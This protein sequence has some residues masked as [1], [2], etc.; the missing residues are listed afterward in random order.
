VLPELERYY[1]A[2]PRSAARVEEVGPFTVFVGTGEWS[3]Y[4][5]PRLGLE[6]QFSVAD[7]EAAAARKREL[8]QPE[9]FE[10]VHETTPSLLPAAR[11]AALEV[12]EAPLMVLDRAAWRPPQLPPDLTLRVLDAG[13]PVLAA[14][15]AVQHVGFGAAGT[16]PGPEGVGERDAAVD[17]EGLD[18]LRERIRRGLTV[19]AIA[20]GAHGPAAA[21]Q[22][23]PVDGVTEIVG[24]ATLPAV[25]RQ[26]LGGAVTGA[27]VEDALERGASTVFLSAGSDDI[28][29]VYARLGFRRIATAC[30]VG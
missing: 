8:G 2:V 19:M 14:A 18:F 26:G 20:E 3:F 30:I 17:E 28:A 5:R 7:I 22:H 27:L 16:E 11:A 25:R 15:R 13:D 6:H 4:A 1:D 21:G 12:L 10:W 29:R 9:S 24:V 23:Q